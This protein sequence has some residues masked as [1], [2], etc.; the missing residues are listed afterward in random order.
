MKVK[1]LIKFLENCN[2]ELEIEIE[3][4]DDRWSME[5]A[6]FEEVYYNSPENMYLNIC[7]TPEWIDNRHFLID[8]DEIEEEEEDKPDFE[9]ALEQFIETSQKIINEHMEQY[10]GQSKNLELMRGRRYIRVVAND[11]V[12]RSAW[13]F[14]DTT[15]GDILKPASWKAPAKHARGNIFGKWNVTPYGPPYLK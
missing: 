9:S 13:A 8:E 12:Q 6:T 2:S 15:N 11:G 1:D 7:L 5:D 3:I 14:I 10:P 4:E